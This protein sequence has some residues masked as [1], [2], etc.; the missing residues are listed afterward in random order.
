MWENECFHSN[1]WSRN[2]ITLNIEI[3]GRIKE[4]EEVEEPNKI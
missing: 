3:F 4:E 1:T 2:G